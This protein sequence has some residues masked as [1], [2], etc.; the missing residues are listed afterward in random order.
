MSDIL[1]TLRK[2]LPYQMPSL[3]FSVAP[4]GVPS[5]QQ[6]GSFAA[7][8]VV[9]QHVQHFHLLMYRPA[10]QDAILDLV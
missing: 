3:T 8:L 10:K 2:W 9:W 5:T 6:E 7:L 4:A 1:L